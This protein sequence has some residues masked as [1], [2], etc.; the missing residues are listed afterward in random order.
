MHAP[1]IRKITSR[2]LGLARPAPLEADPLLDEACRRHPGASPVLLEELREPLRVLVSALDQEARL[3]PL[4][5]FIARARLRQH[6]DHRLAIAWDHQALPELGKQS[7]QAPIFITGLPRTGTTILFHTLAQDPR[8][9]SPLQW[10]LHSPTPP[11]YTDPSDQGKRIAATARSV[12]ALDRLLPELQAVFPIGA[13]LPNECSVITANIFQS[14]LFSLGYEVPS[15]DSWLAGSEF[16]RCYDFHRQFLQQLQWNSARVRWILK[17]PQH[18]LSLDALFEA[19]P[20]A[21]IVH[22]H[23]SPLEEIGSLCSLSAT[24]RSL[25]SDAV[26][27]R[28]LG[29]ALLAFWTDALRRAFDFRSR[30]KDLR[31]RFIDV[32]FGALERDPM[33]EIHRIYREIGLPL[34]PEFD[35]RLRDFLLANPRHRRGVHRYSLETFGLTPATIEKELGWYDVQPRPDS[36]MG[37]R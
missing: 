18:L 25:S 17:S 15:Y 19:Y 8:L 26:A 31:R 35:I 20:D 16:R 7:I 12:N 1:W 4:G 13:A 6:L 9:Q 22:T 5:R 29:P 36:F 32:E 10:M 11:P 2:A 3:S 21:W 34:P 28:T 23:R 37:G 14:I 30:R 27:P 24:L 33:A